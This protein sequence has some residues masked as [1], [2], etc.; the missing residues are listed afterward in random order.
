ML[1]PRVRPTWEDVLRRMFVAGTLSLDEFERL[2]SAAR[3]Q[4]WARDAA[5][6]QTW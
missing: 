6:P 3:A 4:G 2:L 1:T 5:P